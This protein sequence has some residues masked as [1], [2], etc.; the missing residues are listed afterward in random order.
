M[1]VS[2]GTATVSNVLGHS[3]QG[4]RSLAIQYKSRQRRCAR[5]ETPTFSPSAEI[6][7]YFSK[8]GYSLS[9]P[10]IYSGQAIIA[11]LIADEKNKEPVM[12]SLYLKHYNEMDEFT[13][14][15]SEKFLLKPG[16]DH[17]LC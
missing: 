7:K 3:I 9:C 15:S 14:V 16:N 6:S 13:L 10:T 11:S 1:I 17:Q 5:V 8:R 4:T 2:K 12:F